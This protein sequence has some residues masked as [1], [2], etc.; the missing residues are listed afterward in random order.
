MKK[1]SVHKDLNSHQKKTA[2]Q[3]AFLAAL[4]RT[5][6]ISA[7]ARK[8]GIPREV[9]Y[10]WREDEGFIEKFQAAKDEFAEY[11]EALALAR[12]EAAEKPSDTMLIFMMK[13]AMPEKYKDR[14]WQEVSGP[15]G[16]PIE[17]TPKY[18]ELPDEK[19]EEL[20]REKLKKLGGSVQKLIPGE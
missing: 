9:V 20:L 4:A 2:H 14:V 12:V 1:G 5:G 8:V 19:L 18:A 6:T 15:G 11:L 13:G 7:A 16:K 3:Q 17:L 10:D